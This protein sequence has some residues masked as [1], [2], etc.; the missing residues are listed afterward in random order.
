M[1]EK[2]VLRLNR[3]IPPPLPPRAPSRQPPPPVS[4]QFSP[5]TSQSHHLPEP[6][7]SPPADP[8]PPYEST[9]PYSTA[10]GKPSLAT[11]DPRTSSTQSL[12][13]TRS[14]EETDRRRLLLIFIHGFMG[15][16][17]SF[18]SFPA[19]VHNLVANLV[20]DTHVVH[21]KIY[22]RYRSRKNITFARDDFGRW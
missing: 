4:T 2:D 15:N 16:E 13:P 18:Q 6:F 17:T 21:T 3:P 9:I 10:D 14:N 8:P 20:A 22:P 7:Q 5:T 19:H 1:S 12:V 11:N